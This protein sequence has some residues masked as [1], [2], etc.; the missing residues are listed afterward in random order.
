M[1]R[2][3]NLLLLLSALLS[4]LTGAQPGAR[5]PQATIAV[6]QVAARAAAGQVAEAARVGRPVAPLP[7]LSEAAGATPGAAWRLAPAAPLY[8]SRRRE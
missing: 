1:S 6:A 2:T 8:L 3:V 4:A 7:A 5:A